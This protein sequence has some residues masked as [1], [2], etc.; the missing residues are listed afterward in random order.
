MKITILGSGTLSPSTKRTAAGIIIELNRNLLLFDSGSGV[1]YKIA[2]AGFDFHEISY[3]FYTHYEHPDHVN[4]LPFIL[5]A[6]KY[7][8]R[9]NKKD[10]VLTGPSGFS[11]F[12]NKMITLYPVLEELPFKTQIREM[13]E[14]KTDYGIF[15]VDSMP[16]LHGTV[17]SIAY[18]VTYGDK[19][20]VYTGDTDYCKNVVALAHNA[21]ILIT[22]CSY[23]DQL[24]IPNHLS[25][26]IAGEIAAQ[27]GVKKLIL[28]HFYPECDEFDIL[29][30]VKQKF[31][32]E[33]ILSADMM[34]IEI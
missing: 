3:F 15:R 4:D 12:I 5:F 28:T 7:D 16:T 25:P 31:D 21:D 33:I 27:A 32:G 10:I 20:I 18:K 9:E 34:Q 29:N 30:Q 1:Y 8:S 6:K 11:G 26:G 24:K 19:S 2:N 17:K 14:D 22:E 23:P 13:T